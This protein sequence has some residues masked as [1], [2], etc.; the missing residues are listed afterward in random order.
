[1]GAPCC[2]NSSLL[3][4]TAEDDQLVSSTSQALLSSDMQCL[5]AAACNYLLPG[6]HCSRLTSLQHLSSPAVSHLKC[7]PAAAYSSSPP[8]IGPL[9]SV[10]PL[11]KQARPYQPMQW[12]PL[13]PVLDPRVAADLQQRGLPL[14]LSTTLQPPGAPT[15]MQRMPGGLEGSA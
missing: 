5:S 14:R 4:S 7:P 8:S 11:G 13:Q 12:Q 3:H 1:M 2:S 15:G 10:G 6:N 9:S